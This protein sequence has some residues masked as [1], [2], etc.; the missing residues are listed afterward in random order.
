MVGSPENGTSERG[1][2]SDLSWHTVWF[3][4]VS[5]ICIRGGN[6]IAKVESIEISGDGVIEIYTPEELA[7]LLN[8]AP[9]AFVPFITIGAFGGLRT[10][11]IERL[12]WQ[13]VD[14]SGGFIEVKA[15]KAKTRSRRLVP[16]PTNLA[17]WIGSHV[18]PKGNVFEGNVSDARV[19][20][21]KAA[22]IPWKHNGLRHSFCSYRLAQ[23][24]NAAQVALEAG[25]SPTMVFRHYRELVKPEQAKA[26]FSIMPTNTR[27]N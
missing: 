7:K 20:A 2:L 3:C 4:G 19:E 17:Q 23:I 1:E 18:R 8:N 25:N 12:E 21:A 14:L 26:W 10:A 13:D 16:I 9:A 24:Q 15:T 6:P 27:R 22:G 11:E 5:R